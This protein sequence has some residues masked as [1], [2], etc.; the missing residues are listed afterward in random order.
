MV[1]VVY[2]PWKKIVIHEIV[3]YALDDLVKL[4]SLGVEPG[5]LGDPLLWVGGIVFS[6]STMLET[7]DVIKEKLEGS[8]HWS[9]VEWALMPEFK[10][11]IIIKETNVKVPIINVS[12]HPI[13]KTVSK[14]LKEH[15]ELEPK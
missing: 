7:K 5:G 4:Q 12:A 6:S 10:E 8:V 9:S 14:W 13:Y 2:Q 11:V 3:K 1:E 15:K